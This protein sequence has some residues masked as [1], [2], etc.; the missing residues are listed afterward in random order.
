MRTDAAPPLHP[1]TAVREIHC[2]SGHSTSHWVSLSHHWYAGLLCD[3][4]A[5][6]L[7]E[8]VLFVEIGSA[9]SQA[10]ALWHARTPCFYAVRYDGPRKR[11]SSSQLQVNRVNRTVPMHPGGVT[12]TLVLN[13]VDTD[14]RDRCG[15]HGLHADPRLICCRG[16]RLATRWRSDRHHASI[17]E[18]PPTSP[19]TRLPGP[20]C[21]P[22]SHQEGSHD[23]AE[24]Q[25]HTQRHETRHH[26]EGHHTCHGPRR[27]RNDAR[28]IDTRRYHRQARDKKRSIFVT[29]L[30]QITFLPPPPILC[31]KPPS[32]CLAWLAVWRCTS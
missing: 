9:P 16:I 2:S 28:H 7:H 24:P 21:R 4:G 18:V 25:N 10:H 1:G 11:A 13:G 30:T 19:T 14:P 32:L 23:P 31:R 12:C 5:S 6:R 20:S 8:T 15:Q 27:A 22:Q 26:Q 17:A 3:R 29:I